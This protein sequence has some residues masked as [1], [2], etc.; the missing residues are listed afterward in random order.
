ML[1][2]NRKKLL[3]IAATLSLLILAGISFGSTPNGT[4]PAGSKNQT[5]SL[6]D[7][8][9]HELVMLPYLG[10]FD[11]LG[12]S[13]DDSKAVVL[14]GQ[15]V[16]P[17][18]KSDAVLAVKNITGVSKVIDNIEVLP[19]SPFDDAIRIRTF[20]AIF[21]MPG[22]EKYAF[23]AVSPLRIIVKNGN[24]TLIGFVGSQ[25]DKIQAKMAARSIPGAFSVTD[26]LTV[27]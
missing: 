5:L 19:L 6:A 1:K 13:I 9:R 8:V 17:I 12:F 24:I 22:F 16:R 25:M 7:Q 21:S 23:Q 14:S 26:D 2:K 10:I 3:A 18:L 11:N 4:N 27:G 15:V 20:R